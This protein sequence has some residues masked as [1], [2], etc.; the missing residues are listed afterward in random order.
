M[1]ARL[2]CLALTALLTIPFDVGAQEIK[3]RAA[4]QV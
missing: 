4:L 3:L 2:L 1:K